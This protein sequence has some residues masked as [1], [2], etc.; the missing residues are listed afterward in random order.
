[1]SDEN[2]DL[3]LDQTKKFNKIIEASN[4]LL[5]NHPSLEFF[6]VLTLSLKKIVIAHQKYEQMFGK[7]SLGF[8]NGS[9]IVY[10]ASEHMSHAEITATTV[11]EMLHIISDHIARRIDRDPKLWN[12]A[13]DQVVNTVCK[14][15]EH[16]C[17]RIVKVSEGAFLDMD[18]YNN[19]NIK[20]NS[21]EFFYE[22]FKKK[23]DSGEYT[24]EVI[25]MSDFMAAQGQQPGGGG[26]N[27][28]NQPGQQ[29]GQQPGGNGNQPGQGQGQGQSQLNPDENYVVKITNNKTGQTTYS[30]VN[31]E[32]TYTQQAIENFEALKTDAS[33]LWNSEVASKTKG[34]LP[35]EV[36][37]VLDNY[38]KVKIPWDEILEDSI[39][40]SIQNKQGTSWS[41]VNEVFRRLCRLPGPFDNPI[42][43]AIV[44][45][46]DS[47]GSIPDKDLKKAIAVVCQSAQYYDKIYVMYHDTH[48]PKVWE[49]TDAPSPE[50][51]F[52]EIKQVPCRGGTSHAHVFKIIDELSEEVNLS[53]IIF[54]T[55]YYSDVEYVQKD[56]EFLQNYP[57]IWLISERGPNF[58]V[59]LDNAIT[60]TITIDK[61]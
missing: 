11:H 55:D 49:F 24:L 18:I 9:E 16:K 53:S 25:P 50:T 59:V 42:Q 26:G 40:Y 28:P 34:N 32:N 8:T 37:Q 7:T 57:T 30:N 27:Q 13:A 22:M 21:A 51:I 29:P 2:V 35:A 38:F 54:C 15:I 5:L 47:S 39:L 52:E 36:I 20:Y 33:I 3:S 45:A 56:Y 4:I 10:L 46:I 19:A 48:A 44:F 61:D 23:Q 43:D 12:L 14:D 58:E 6:G 17:H 41:S 31:S 60:K 1:M